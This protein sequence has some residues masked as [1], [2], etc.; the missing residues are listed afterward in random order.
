MTKRKSWPNRENRVAGYCANCRIS[1]RHHRVGSRRSSAWLVRLPV[2]EGKDL[3][4]RHLALGEAPNHL[5]V[6]QIVQDDLGFLWLATSDGLKRYDGYRIRDFRHDADNP[7]SPTDNYTYTLFKDRSG[8]I[9]VANGNRYLQTYDPATE[10]FTLFRLDPRDPAALKARVG[11]IKQ[12]RA[13][14]IWLSTD[15]GLYRID[16]ATGRTVHYEHNPKDADTLSSNIVRST[17][18]TQ[19]GTPGW[20]LR[21]VWTLSIAGPGKS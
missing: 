8:K 21:R 17:L 4:F 11:E 15:T 13:G 2:A 6:N 7:N 9:W 12:D 3:R 18:E 16:A 10:K 1:H 14:A 19:D 20:Q 5:R